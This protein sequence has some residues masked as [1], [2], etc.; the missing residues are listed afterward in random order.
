MAGDKTFT[1]SDK[2]INLFL[3]VGIDYKAG[4]AGKGVDWETV[5]SKYEDVTKMFLEKYHDVDKEDFPQ[6]TEA[7]YVAVAHHLLI[8]VICFCFFCLKFNKI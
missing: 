5:R 2:E 1:W 3:H 8:S 4:K 7:M 6:C